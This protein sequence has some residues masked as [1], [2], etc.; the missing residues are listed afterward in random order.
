MSDIVD[1]RGLS[2]PQPVLD[3]LAMIAAKGSG[4]IEVLVDTEASK[5]NV[6][7]AAQAKGW[8]VASIAE[9]AGGYRLA[10]AKG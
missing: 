5:E 4:R 10:L 6:A 1:A 2:C 8:T 9:E 7:R 3:T